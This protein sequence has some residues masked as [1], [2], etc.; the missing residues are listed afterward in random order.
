MKEQGEAVVTSA[1]RAFVCAALKEGMRVDGRS[2]YDYRTLR[3]VRLP[4]RALHPS[5]Q[6]SASSLTSTSSSAESSSSSATLSG[7][8]LLQVRLPACCEALT[9]SVLSVLTLS[10]S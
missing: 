4:T 6:L 10:R 3:L 9:R 8:Y 2:P 7:R 1:E 5:G